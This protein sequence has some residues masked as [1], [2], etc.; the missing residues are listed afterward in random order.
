MRD[1][2][3][4]IGAIV[5]AALMLPFQP[6]TLILAA[7]IGAF[8]F[9]W[10]YLWGEEDML[11]AR[12]GWC[13]LG[14][15]VAAGAAAIYI[16]GEYGIGVTALANDDVHGIVSRVPSYAVAFVTCGTCIVG[17]WLIRRWK[18]LPPDHD[19]F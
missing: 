6:P 14:L 2:G 9:A 11:N 1:L 16:A 19:H 10:G 7:V 17:A 8:I 12:L 5:I 3:F 4:R 15:G 13:L 18:R